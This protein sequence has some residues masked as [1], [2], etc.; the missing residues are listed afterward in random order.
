MNQPNQTEKFTKCVVIEMS[1][2][3][4]WAVPASIVADHRARYYAK[5]DCDRDKNLDFE[6]RRQEELEF[7]LRDHAELCD[8]MSNNMNWKDVVFKAKCIKAPQTPSY[9]DE[10]CNALKSVAPIALDAHASACKPV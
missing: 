6:T 4:E 10:F 9:E 5:I 1:D 3:S 8:W 7:A 2:G